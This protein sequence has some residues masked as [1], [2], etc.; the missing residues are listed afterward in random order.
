MAAGVDILILTYLQKV[1]F[2]KYRINCVSLPHNIILC[3]DFRG[4]NSF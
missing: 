3:C 2:R 1:G 4:K